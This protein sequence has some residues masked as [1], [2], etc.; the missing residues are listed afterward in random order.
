MRGLG[1]REIGEEEQV[2]QGI[3]EF[4]GEWFRILKLLH[5]RFGLPVL[6]PV[7]QNLIGYGRL[8]GELASWA[9]E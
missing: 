5:R 8:P 4:F 3:D 7:K 9:P 2:E 1:D 6:P